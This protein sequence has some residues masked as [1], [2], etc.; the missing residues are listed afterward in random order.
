MTGVPGRR[1]VVRVP[2]FVDAHAHFH[3]T[4][5]LPV[6]LSA[7]AR[8]VSEAAIE[9][10]MTAEPPVGVLLLAEGRH[11]GA[12]ERLQSAAQSEMHAWSIQ[13]T[14]ERESLLIRE[15]GRLALIVMA[16]RQ[17]VTSE[18]V[19]VLALLSAEPFSDGLPLTDT[20]AAI[21]QVGALPVLPWGFGKWTMRRRALVASV[22]RSAPGEVFLGDNGGRLAAGPTP[23]LLR[24]ARRRTVPVLPGSDPLP[25]RD[26]QS[27]IATYGF[28]AGVAV[29]E[30]RPASGLRA[31]LQEL[32]AQP[33]TYGHLETLGRFIR[34]QARMQWRKR[35]ARAG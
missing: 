23:R 17:I 10:G 34:N 19:E 30:D 28:V 22:F 35:V 7:A 11:E 27:R 9:R 21:Q 12:F 3:R 32:D 16:G 20:V 24:E 1:G 5:E 14:A 2:L 29:E 18:G 26:E 31:W 33:P 25:F 4:F 6:F 8:N 15:S 13:S